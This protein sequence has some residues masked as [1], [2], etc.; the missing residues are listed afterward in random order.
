MEESRDTP[1]NFQY[2]KNA[3]NWEAC[4]PSQSRYS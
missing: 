2:A 1:P 4:L 3:K